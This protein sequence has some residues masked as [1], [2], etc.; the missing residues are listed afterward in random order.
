MYF[1]SVCTVFLSCHLKKK[2]KTW[3]PQSCPKFVYFRESP[4]GPVV[5]SPH[6]YC[7]EPWLSPWL[8][9]WD[10][11]CCAVWP[12]KKEPTAKK[13]KKKNKI[14]QKTNHKHCWSSLSICIWCSLLY[15]FSLLS[16]F[17]VVLP[18]SEMDAWFISSNPLWMCSHSMKI[19]MTDASHR[20]MWCSREKAPCEL[21]PLGDVGFSGRVSLFPCPRPLACSNSPLYRERFFSELAHCW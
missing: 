18:N 9:H 3:S 7:W 1:L 17:L 15:S 4:W 10:P 12:K 21:R 20:V 13:K 19:I 16:D 11:I 6:S 14:F 5:R 8:E 2:K